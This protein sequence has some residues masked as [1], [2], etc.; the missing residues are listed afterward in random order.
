M[1]EQKI[2]ELYESEGKS[3][4]EIAEYLNTYPNKIRRVLKRHGVQLKGKSEAQKNALKGGRAKHPTDGKKRTKEEKIKISSSI[5]QYWESMDQVERERRTIEARERWYAMS[6]EERARISK[7]GIEAI[8]KA[9]KEGSKLE[10]F[11]K[12]EL[13]SVGYYV[14]F[15]RKNLIPNEKLEIDLYI[16]ELQTIIEVDGPSHFLPIWGADKLQKQIKADFHK[17]GLILGKGF[18]II[19]I[20]NMGGFVS[21]TK[22]EK[23]IKTVLHHLD[24]IK[25]KFPPQSKRLIEIEK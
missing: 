14:D 17:T 16:P 9:G 13:N 11:L 12:E 6:E 1:N 19:R 4:Y 18:V 8:Q 10:K 20:K 24:S 7:L 22:K 25:S 21:L 5:H 2:I 23:L 15:H 3:T